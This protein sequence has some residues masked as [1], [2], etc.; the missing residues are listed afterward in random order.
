MA[1]ALDQH[2]FK[3]VPEPVITSVTAGAGNTIII[4]GTGL[5]LLTTKHRLTIGLSVS[6]DLVLTSASGQLTSNTATQLIV[7][8]DAQ[9]GED[10]TD[11][12]RTLPGVFS[13]PFDNADVTI[14]P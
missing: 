7:D 3:I 8:L 2:Y 4:D 5:A 9:T 6:A 1:T 11:V 10:V 14:A 12:L 13:V